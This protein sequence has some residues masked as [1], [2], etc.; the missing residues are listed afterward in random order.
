MDSHDREGAHDR[1]GPLRDL[2]VLDCSTVLAGPLACQVLA[3]FGADVIKIEHPTRGDSMRGHGHQVNG[4]G[5]WWKIVSRNKRCIGL[6]LSDPEAAAVFERLAA[7]ADVVLENFRPGTLERWG[8]GWERLSQTNPDLVLC[9]VTGFGQDGPYSDRPAFGT[10]MEAM[11][12]FAYMTGA[13]EGPP[14]LPPFGLAD[15]IAGIVA[16]GA[17]LM[18]LR[19]R[20]AGGGGQVVDLSILEPITTALGPHIAVFDQLG[21]IARRSGNRSSNNAPRNIYAT[22]DGDWVA[23]STS[24]EPVAE[25]ALRLVGHPE[26][27]EEPW[28]ATGAGRAA[29]ADELDE[30]MSSW[31]GERTTEEVTA[32]FEDA[33]VALS[34][35]Y[36][37]ADYVSD[38]QVI[39]RGSVVSV[40]DEDLGALSMQNVLFRLS[41]TPGRIRHTGRKLGADTDE[42]L[43]DELGLS[44]ESIAE[45]RSRKA[46]A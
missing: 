21:Q 22:K 35:V 41:A 34:L 29:H 40:P 4:Q 37:V 9:R 18:A 32:A 3:D 1:E 43:R 28:F 31:I 19:H 24:S 45:M 14:T 38:P 20:D 42:I 5:L 7:S 2:R 16:V 44:P 12:G 6:D 46:A 33:Q 10:L 23:V 36:S 26:V 11:S 15:S 30:M 25:R 8:L 17:V 27:V 39:H 13:A